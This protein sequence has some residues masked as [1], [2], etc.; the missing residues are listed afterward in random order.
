MIK[1]RKNDMAVEREIAAFLDEHLY[2]NA[3]MFS[4]FARTDD[5][6]EQLA[7]SDLVLS[8]SDGKLNRAVVDE[9]VAS[10]Y[11][12]S[13]LDTFALELSFIGR[14]GQKRCGWLLDNTKAT[15]Y[16]LFGW[17]TKA[18]I[19]YLDGKKR[20]DTNK[21]TRDNIREM[22]WVLVSKDKIIKF[23]E[24][25]GWTLDRLA[26]QDE[27][28]RERGTVVTKDFINGVSFRYSGDYIEK[29][30]NLLLKKD[31]Y[32]ELSDYNGIINV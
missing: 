29:P 15:Q 20:Y 13:G 17:I 23:L 7:G 21:L 26:R 6:D 30:I 4:E 24:K 1:N 14:L 31:T 3:D 32:K 18:D 11:A 27:R 2:S 22:E 12:C 8:T 5:R 25:K 9:K 10:R 16:F 19:P 28:I